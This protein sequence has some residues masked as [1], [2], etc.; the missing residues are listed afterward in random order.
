MVGSFLVWN[1]ILWK[2]CSQNF[3]TTSDAYIIYKNPNQYFLPIYAYIYYWST[4]ETCFFYSLLVIFLSIFNSFLEYQR[5]NCLRIY[6]LHSTHSIFNIFLL[7]WTKEV[8]LW[9]LLTID[10]DRKICQNVDFVEPCV[11][12]RTL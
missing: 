12:I 5:S 8:K 6:C 1:W 2:T 4:S 10:F 11:N 9:N 7:S 3:H